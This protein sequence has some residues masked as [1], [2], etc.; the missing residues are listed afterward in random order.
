MMKIGNLIKRVAE[1]Y[2][3]A[4]AGSNAWMCTGSVHPIYRTQD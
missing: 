2:F 1:A 3:R 4:C